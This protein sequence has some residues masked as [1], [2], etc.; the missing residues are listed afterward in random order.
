[1]SVG[2]SGSKG[3][4]SSQQTQRVDIPD[5]LQNLIR[6]GTDTASGALS[7]L[8]N[9]AGQN[10]VAGFSPDQIAAQ[11]QARDIAG[12]AGGFIP[13]AQ[14]Q[15]LQTAQGRSL[16]DILGPDAFSALSGQARGTGLGDFLNPEALGALEGTARGDFLTGGAGFQSALDAG[17][18]EA[19]RAAANAFGGSAG[20]VGSGLSREAVGTGTADAFSRLFG[21]E[22]QNMLSASNTLA[23]LSDAERSRRLSSAGILS[24]FSNAER[25]R[26][27]NAVGNLPDA[28][29]LGSNLLQQIG[30]Q[31]QGLEQQGLDQGFNRQL[32]LLQAALAGTPISDL[33]GQSGEGSSRQ[34]GFTLG[35]GPRA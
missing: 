29:L 16:Q 24:N 26:Q 19:Q 17:T 6:Q 11:N 12:G 18:R 33:L 3:R 35:F 23:G 28:G 32:Q 30:G 25:N 1:M 8:Q 34:S 10:P 21:Q 20:G 27:D 4:S 13:T 7:N 5:F 31:I 2:G 22:R 14:D 9:L 15:T